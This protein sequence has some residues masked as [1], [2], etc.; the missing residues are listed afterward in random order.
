[1]VSNDVTQSADK[2]NAKHPERS[3]LGFCEELSKQVAR[4]VEGRVL[5]ETTLAKLDIERV[6]R[7]R[8]ALCMILGIGIRPSSAQ[9][10]FLYG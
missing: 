3:A 6:L 7:L 4:V 9:D 1:M 5:C 2:L 10:A 8:T